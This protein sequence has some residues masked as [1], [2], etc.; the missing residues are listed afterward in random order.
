MYQIKQNEC[1]QRTMKV[2]LSMLFCVFVAGAVSAQQVKVSG[3]ITDETGLGLPGVNILEKGTLNGTIT[4][5]DGSYMLS[6]A[7]NGTLVV[8]FTGYKTVELAVGSGGKKDYTMEVDSKVL[9]EVVVTGYVAQQKKDLTGAVGVVNTTELIKIPS[10]NLT[11]QLQGRVS[12]V[13]VGGD[14]SPGGVAKVRIRGLTS[15]SGANDPLYIVDGVPTQDVSSLNPN[16]IENMSVLKD[17]GAASIYGSRAANGVILITT[18]RGQSKGVKVSYDTYVGSQSPNLGGLD[19]LNAQEYADLQWL[20]YKNDGTNEVHPVYG[21]STNAKP[22]LPAWAGDTDWFKVISRNA[23]IMNHD[24]SF[25]GGNENARFYAGLNYFNQEGIIINNFFQRY[26][27]RVNSEFKIAKGRITIGE[28]LTITGR[29]GLGVSRNGAEE[30]PISRVYMSQPI[31]PHLITKPVQGSAYSYKVGDFGGTGIASRLGSTPNIYADLTRDQYDRQRDIR[32]L[33]S[34]YMDVKLMEGLNFKS[35]FGGSYQNGYN[36]DWTSATYERAENQA[37]SSYSESGYYNNDW[38]WTNALTYNKSFDSHNILAVAGYEAVKYD[39]GRGLQAARAGYFSS[40]PAF[41]TVNN[42]AQ[43]TASTSYFSTPTT[44]V[45][46]FARADYNYDNKYYLSATV[47]RDGSSRFGKD[48]RYGTFPSVSAG[49]RLTDFIGSSSFL[50]D[51]KVRGG[52][53]TMGNQLPVNPANQ[54][55]LFGGGIG[56]SNYD[57]NGSSTS[58]LQGFR[59]TRLGNADTKWETQ[60]T[61]N[62]GFDA[63]LL[64]SK[65]QLSVDLYQKKSKDLLVTIPLPSIYGAADA[66]ALNVGD[67]QNTGID[68]QLDYKEKITSDLSFDA[69]LTFTHYKNKII[70]YTDDIDFF[71]AGGSRIGGFNRNQIEMPMSMFYGYNVVGL[72]Q[73][74][75]EVDAAPD[76]DGAEAGFFRYEDVD[77]DKAITPKDR[78]FIGNPHPDFTY[79]LN[80]GL[81]YKSFDVSA[82]F[83]GSQGNEI[84]N[85]NKWWLDFWQSFQNQKSAALLYNSWTP[86][87][88][89]TNVPKASNKSNFSNNTQSVSYYVEDGSFFRLRTLQVGYT[90]PKDLLDKAGIGSAR[91]YLQGTNLFTLTKYSG[92]DPDVNNGADTNFGVDFGNYP[93]TRQLMVGLNLSF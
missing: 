56:D 79:G 73:N 64:D 40:D 46:N 18:K 48:F 37:S 63:S 34:M 10:S 50:T 58:S 74:Q 15:F 87:R 88:T 32:L 8:S 93:L 49:V 47:R 44:L 57:L 51:L 84:F 61:T 19:L 27:A 59:P 72:F 3:I 43:I 26:S 23:M 71:D 69:T 92:I 53:G 14:G 67:M 68:L 7:T 77:G 70:K 38:V 28:N 89:D 80:L 75:A 24:L 82:Y 65:L 66:P 83:F 36:T 91:V 86:Q 22:T 33:G 45:S 6:V 5:V 54:F 81:N 35:T 12:G 4:D 31:I 85:Y 13:T 76:Q 62:I 2:M 21:P 1:I 17:A 25:S 60:I 9:E 78:T 39:M 11:S 41:R 55:N 29:N 20:V 16:D 42:G 90:M 30:S 52:Y